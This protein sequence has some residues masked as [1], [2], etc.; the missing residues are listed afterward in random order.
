MPQNLTP[1]DF[2]RLLTRAVAAPPT[3]LA[4]LAITYVA[5]V[6]YLLSAARW[7]DHTDQVIARA[8]NVR[9]LLVDGETGARGYLITA[10]PVFLK[11]YQLQGE[12]SGV[13]FQELIELVS[14]N[15]VQAKRFQTLRDDLSGWRGRA[16]QVIALRQAGGDYQAA[17]GTL[18]GKRR[19]DA[20]REQVA[21]II[22]VEER[23]RDERTRTVRVATWVIVVLSLASAATVAA[24]LA[25]S[26]RQQLVRV[27]ATYQQ[28]LDGV[29][30]QAKSLRKAVYRL[31]T[32][33]EI[34]RTILD[35]HPIRE[36]T[37]LALHRMSNGVPSE[38]AVVV[39]LRSDGGVSQVISR[40]D[41]PH[42]GDITRAL[43]E[44]QPSEF[45]GQCGIESTAD[46]SAVAG[47]SHLQKR[48]SEAGQ[49]SCVVA[50]VSIGERKFGML[51]L[52]DTRVSALTDEHRDVA[53]EVTRQLAI[54]FQ[55]TELR[56][57]IRLHAEEL[58][59]RV[60]ERTRELREALD[61]VKQLQGLLPICAW[62]KKVRNDQNYWQDVEHYVVAHTNARFS[63]G[64][65]PSCFKTNAEGDE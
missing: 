9:G 36:V 44:S 40:D 35:A 10:D 64:I 27:A 48:L 61:N 38:N 12:Q 43:E 19:M 22:G 8:Q 59:R 54:A 14:D 3:L 53:E 21:T 31:G 30:A 23:L 45:V 33:H 4:A 32:L 46:L 25:R 55:Q 26:T 42:D 24:V 49:R 60:D 58:E 63:H 11:P 7:V 5:Q 37:R 51:I 56:E 65:C 17:V 16:E 62:C 57:Q 1:A 18:E 50:P 13:A 28:A 6:A 2:G 34:D 20:M 15:P 39:A 52:A 41:S 47:Q 29:E